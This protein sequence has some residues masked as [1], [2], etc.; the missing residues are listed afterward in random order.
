MK[1]IVLLSFVLVVSLAVALGAQAPAGGPGG[2]GGGRGGPGG[3]AQGG[4]RGAP[5]APATGPLAD[6]TNKFIESWNK[7][8]AT[9]LNS[10]LTADALWLDEDGHMV[11]ATAWITKGTNGPKKLA[12][13]GLRVHQIG[14]TSGWAAFNY[15]MDETATP[16]GGTAGPN[17]MK[18][19]ASIV[20]EKVGADWKVTL[21]HVPVT[22]M[23]VTPH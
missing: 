1:K 20:F 14:E 19:L 4:G 7:A 13:T 15:T 6:L 9:Y 5:A 23:A 16:R 8:D 11:P 3:G 17:T 21:V 10:I 22:G 18:G 2:P 12:I